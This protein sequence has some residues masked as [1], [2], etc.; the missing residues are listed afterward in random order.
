[1]TFGYQN[2]P[3]PTH[4]GI[5]PYETTESTILL[6][7]PK[8][9]TKLLTR[10]CVISILTMQAQG[11]ILALLH[12]LFEP[13]LIQ[14]YVSLSNQAVADMCLIRLERFILHTVT[15]I[16]NESVYLWAVIH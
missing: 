14:V 9:P 10:Q 13:R 7:I 11:G 12:S 4:K 1:M 15:L 3:K 2:A 5:M 6:I 16:V 8:I